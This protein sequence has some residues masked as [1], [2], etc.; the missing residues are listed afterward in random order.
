[1]ANLQSLTITGNQMVLPTGNSA[2][3]PG[4]PVQGMMRFNTETGSIEVYSGTEWIQTGRDR[5]YP[6]LTKW[7]P[8]TSG[9]ELATRWSWLS[10]GYYWI[11]NGQMPNPLQMYVDMETEGGGYDFYLIE[12]GEAA[13]SVRDV[14]AGN[15]RSPSN[16]F[17]SGL[18]LGLDLIYPR[19]PYHWDAMYKFCNNV[20]GLSIRDVFANFVGAVFRETADS[21]GS[22]NGNYD[23]GESTERIMRNP[24]YYPSRGGV[25]GAED[26]RVPDNGRWWLRRTTYGEPNGDYE[27]RSLLGGRGLPT[28]WNPETSDIVFNDLSRYDHN[29][30]STYL[31]STN[32][33]P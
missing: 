29:T 32:T 33:K 19:S 23:A 14:V 24:R 26:W 16:S 22:V 20:L 28:S 15:N 11:K 13:F 7:N 9:Y 8:A 1:M 18:V 4:S 27:L 2:Q 17:H 30:Q 6:G 3:R 21:G 12:N 5:G 31:V 25:P 10:S